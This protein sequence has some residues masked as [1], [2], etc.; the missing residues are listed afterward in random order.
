MNGAEILAYLKKV[1]RKA[2][3]SQN[4]DFSKFLI[5]VIGNLDEAY[6]MSG[7]ISADN[8]PDLMYEES[9]KISFSKIKNAL[10]Y[11][12]RLEEIA[13]LCSVHLLYP[14]LSSEV[15]KSFID[16]ELDEI[17]MRFREVFTC[18][19]GFSK[20]VKAV[21]FEVGVVAS[22]G[23][24]PLRSS[25]RYLKES[26]LFELLQCIPHKFMR[27]VLVDMEG[28]DLTIIVEGKVMNQKTLHLPI[29]EAKRRKQNPEYSAITAV[30]KAGHALVYILLRHRLPKILS[31]ASSD[32]NKGGYMGTNTVKFFGNKDIFIREIA[33]RLA[34]KKAEELVFGAENITEGGELD[35]KIA[36]KTVLEAFRDGCLSEKTTAFGSKSNGSGRLLPDPVETDHWVLRQ[37]AKG[38][39][40][41]GEMLESHLE[42][43][44]AIVELLLEK[45]TLDEDSLASGLNEK[46]IDF[47]QLFKAFPSTFSYSHQVREFFEKSMEKTRNEVAAA[48]RCSKLKYAAEESGIK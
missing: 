18:K 38:Y 6:E 23:F 16:R 34:G 44:Q 10:S 31:I 24:R 43:F 5:I 33:V 42:A 19:L 46:G 17:G 27:E 13:R 41:A 4:M 9:K 39:G 25:I 26:N 48:C 3:L 14:S 2:L 22:Q 30:H 1:E 21:L 35:V 7:I 28:D 37:L 29:R 32:Q 40:L 36:T 12:F 45:R 47:K 11:R 15:Y 20:K 8:D